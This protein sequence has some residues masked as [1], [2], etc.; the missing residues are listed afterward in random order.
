MARH[1]LI[2]EILAVKEGRAFLIPWFLI[3][4]ESLML[5]WA[6]YPFITAPFH[7]PFLFKPI[8]SI[9]ASMTT[10][11][12]TSLFTSP[13][14]NKKSVFVLGDL[15]AFWVLR[16]PGVKWAFS[17]GMNVREH[18]PP[19]P[20]RSQ[21]SGTPSKSGYNWTEKIFIKNVKLK[22]S[23]KIFFLETAFEKLNQ[24]KWILPGDSLEPSP[25]KGLKVINKSFSIMSKS[26]TLG[27]TTREPVSSGPSPSVL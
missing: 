27:Q 12:R 7:Y 3:H 26:R 13:R 9:R 21:K 19:P 10:S 22:V 6:V 14:K 5:E 2:S 11:Q 15:P 16:S 24:T 18:P 25:Q 23:R 20:L 1:P 4:W 8:S 17:L